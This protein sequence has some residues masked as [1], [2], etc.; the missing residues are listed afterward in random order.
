MNKLFKAE[1]FCRVIL[2]SEVFSKVEDTNRLH[3]VNNK[4]SYL[5]NLE[6]H[7]YDC[8]LW[9]ISGMLCSYVMPYIAHLRAIY[10][11]YVSYCLTKDAFILCNFCT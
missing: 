7:M 9:Q 8:G 10:K 1:R 11:P 5:V 6:D 3:I 4:N 2:A